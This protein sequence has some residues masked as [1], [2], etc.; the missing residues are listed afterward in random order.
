MLLLLNLNTGSGTSLSFSTHS[1]NPHR[2]GD[3]RTETGHAERP[4]GSL[5]GGCTDTERGGETGE[6]RGAESRE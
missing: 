4:T 6:R 3:Q 5:L 1:K 2:V